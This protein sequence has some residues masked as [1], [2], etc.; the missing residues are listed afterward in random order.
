[1]QVLETSAESE[2][3]S[4]EAQP[5]PLVRRDRPA[6]VLGVTDRVRTGHG[7]MYVTISFDEDDKPFEI[8]TALGK[9]GG[10]DS[11]NLEAVSR[12]ASLAL[13]AGIAPTIS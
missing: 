9:A 12:L 13:R 8:F 3:A 1:M 11:A 7:N 6:S 4:N 2:D 5:A 10:C